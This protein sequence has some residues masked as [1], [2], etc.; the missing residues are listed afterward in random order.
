MHQVPTLTRRCPRC[1][2][3]PLRPVEATHG[4]NLLCTA[5]HR[6][7]ESEFGYLVE[8]N[9]HACPGCSDQHL[10]SIT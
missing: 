1:G 9:R 7:W 10:C 5:C 4:T 2:S 6:C 8:V 3:E